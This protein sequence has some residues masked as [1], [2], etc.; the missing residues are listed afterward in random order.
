M[1]KFIYLAFILAIV[2]SCATFGTASVISTPVHNSVVVAST[3]DA[4]LSVSENK[5][6]YKYYPNKD[7]KKVLSIDKLVE[8]AKYAALQANGNSDVMVN[9]AVYVSVYKNKVEYISVS[10]YPAKY[11]DFKSSD[12][13]SE[14]SC[15]AD[16]SSPKM[17]KKRGLFR[18]R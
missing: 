5:I 16:S 14:G 18:R 3:T 9:V 2:S 10:G 1:K 7:E 13:I 17:L 6:T 15:A 8:N 11:I 4:K 12:R